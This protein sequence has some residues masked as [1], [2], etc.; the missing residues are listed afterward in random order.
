MRPVVIKRLVVSF[1]KSQNIG[2]NKTV[3][4]MT[5]WI[6]CLIVIVKE[7]IRNMCVEELELAVEPEEARVFSSD[8]CSG[9]GY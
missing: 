9:W 4:S 3:S 5:C 2:K 1:F 6:V 8:F 7:K